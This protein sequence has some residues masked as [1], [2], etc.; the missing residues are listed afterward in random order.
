MNFITYICVNGIPA[1]NIEAG[2]KFVVEAGSNQ[3]NFFSKMPEFF[4]MYI[5]EKDRWHIGDWVNISGKFT[6]LT[7]PSKNGFG[8]QYIKNVNAQ[9][10]A[11]KTH[12]HDTM[13]NVHFT[14]EDGTVYE[15]LN[16]SM[17]VENTK[18][19]N[20][21]EKQNIVKADDYWFI[22]SRGQ[23]CHTFTNKDK[24]ADSWRRISGNCFTSKDE[25]NAYKDKIVTKIVK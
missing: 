14:A 7:H 4:I 1:L 19:S 20:P 10:T 18:S 12:A 16:M 24:D 11:M 17:S 15:L 6:N 25:A 22:N 9:I 13:C 2:R 3:S 8:Y 23:I 21:R 5:D